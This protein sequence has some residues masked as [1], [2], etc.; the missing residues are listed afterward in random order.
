MFVF[1]ALSA[2]AQDKTGRP[3]FI[4]ELNPV[5]YRLFPTKNAWTFIKLDTR[6]GRMWQVQWDTG[7]GQ[8]QTPLSTMSRITGAEEKNGRFCLYPTDNIYNFILLDQEDGRV[9]QV[10]WSSQA[11]ERIV[12]PIE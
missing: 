10:Q 2:S 4:S 9:W 12:I 1:L 7:S 5:P 8:L 3:P 6:N 11:K